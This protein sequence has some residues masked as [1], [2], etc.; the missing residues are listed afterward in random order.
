M[1]LKPAFRQSALL[2]NS[3]QPR[4]AARGNV[5]EMYWEISQVDGTP[6]GSLAASGLIRGSRPPVAP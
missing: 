5:I 1:E 3:F 6:I 4:I 2:A